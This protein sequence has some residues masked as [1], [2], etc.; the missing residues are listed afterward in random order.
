MLDK[1]KANKK[2]IAMGLAFVAGGLSAIGY[3]IP[4][5]VIELVYSLLGLGGLQ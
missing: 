1:I 2:G 4:A 3:G 5:P